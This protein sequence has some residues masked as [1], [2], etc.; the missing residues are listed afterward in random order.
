MSEPEKKKLRDSLKTFKTKE[1]ET[2]QE[3]EKVYPWVFTVGTETG[4]TATSPKVGDIICTSTFE[5]T[6]KK[7]GVLCNT[8]FDMDSAQAQ[9]RE[10]RSKPGGIVVPYVIIC[11]ETRYFPVETILNLAHKSLN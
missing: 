2:F 4:N 9:L 5:Y 10:M 7:D 11:R 3:I 8:H 1:R 6:T